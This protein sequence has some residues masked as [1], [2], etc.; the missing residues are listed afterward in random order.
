MKSFLIPVAFLAGMVFSFSGC[1]PVF[2]AQIHMKKGNYNHAEKLLSSRLA[3]HPKDPEALFLMGK[4]HYRLGEAQTAQE[5]LEKAVQFRDS[6]WEAHIF[7]GL[8]C[9]KTND[10]ICAMSVFMNQSF[11]D[12][13]LIESAVT[14]TTKELEILLDTMGDPEENN[15]HEKLSLLITRME[16][17]LKKQRE[18]EM[19]KQV[20]PAGAGGGNDSGG[21]GEGG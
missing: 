4:V 14:E 16:K 9:L 21:G 20:T 18:K 11:P 3:S 5:Y 13:P 1:S 19:E 17:A 2:Q 8:S 6:P 10:I 15:L 12:K 7:L